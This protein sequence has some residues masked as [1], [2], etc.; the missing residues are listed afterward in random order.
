MI[1][2]V[3]DEDMLRRLARRILEASGYVVYE[4]RNGP[5]GM[6]SR[7]RC[8]IRP[9]NAQTAWRARTRI[10]HPIALPGSRNTRKCL[11]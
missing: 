1:L 8:A 3:K 10:G 4:A 7:K 9:P 6:N 11:Y 5:E 2:P